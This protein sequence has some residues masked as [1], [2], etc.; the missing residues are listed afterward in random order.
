M[1]SNIENTATG[2]KTKKNTLHLTKEKST[3][4]NKQK[5]SS[6]GKPSEPKANIESNEF[7]SEYNQERLYL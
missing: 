3:K 1:S 6:S 7:E 5:P 2:T 4:S